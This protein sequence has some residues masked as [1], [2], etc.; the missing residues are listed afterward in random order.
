MGSN[1][2]YIQQYFLLSVVLLSLPHLA[3]AQ[4]DTS[5]PEEIVTFL[6]DNFK[7]WNVAPI[8]DAIRK[9]YEA[10]L[11]PSHSLNYITGDFN[12]DKSTD[13]AVYIAMPR[14]GGQGE[15]Y[16][17]FV[18]VMLRTNNGFKKYVLSQGNSTPYSYLAFIKAGT[19]GYNVDTNETI[20]FEFDSFSLA[21]YEKGFIRYRY[22]GNKFVIGELR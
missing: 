2:G 6:N 16:E 7:E 14:T 10:V 1:P 18:V 11:N 20:K 4:T 22:Q 17:G 12:G 9:Q 19:D 13:Y 15:S 5:L 21:Y 3:F 8:H